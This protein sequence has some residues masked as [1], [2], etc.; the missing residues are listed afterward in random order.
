MPT[1]TID[2]PEE[3]YQRVIAL[4]IAERERRIISAFSV[5]INAPE[6][7]GEPLSDADIASINAGLK[8]MDAGDERDGSEVFAAMRER[9]GEKI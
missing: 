5:A 1:I 3:T 7:D 4:P 9:F 8:A 2:V 6:R